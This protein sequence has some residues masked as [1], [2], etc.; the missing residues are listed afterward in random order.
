MQ[1]EDQLPGEQISA[2]KILD[3]VY[4]KRKIVKPSTK[5]DVLDLEELRELQRRKRAEFET[6]LKRNKLDIGQWIR[7]A[8]F[9]VEQRDIRRAR[10][11]FERALLVD[12]SHVPLWIRYIDTEIKLK[13]I[14]HARNLLNRA[15]GVLPRVDKFW[16]KYLII[17]ESLGNLEIVR[18]LFTKWISLEPGPNAWE[19]FVSF[20][21]RQGNWNHVREVFAKYVLVHPK[22]ETWLRWVNFETVHGDTDTVR[23]VYSLALDTTVSMTEK[24]I[25]NDED[26]A[27]LIV[28]FADWEG[29]QQEY[30][31]CRQLYKVSVQRWPHN[32]LLK[33]GLLNFEKRF[34]DT[35][36][37]EQGVLQRRRRRYE[38]SLKETP[39]DYDTCW[40][41]L[42]LI[43]N[44]FATDMLACF[45]SSVAN[46]QPQEVTKTS[47]WK[48]YIYLWIRYLAYVELEVGNIELCRELYERLIHLIP[49][50]KFTFAKVWFMYSQFEVRN[51]ELSSARRIMGKALGM[52]PKPKIFKLYIDMEVKLKEF[53][54]VRKLYEKYIEY[55]PSNMNAWRA[56]AE[57]ESNL[58]DHQRAVGIYEMSLMSDIAPLSNDSRIEQ[59][60]SFID[61]VTDQEE[62]DE[63]R[64]LFERFLEMSNYSVESWVKYALFESDT[65]TMEQAQ[66]LREQAK[67]SKD[68]DDEIEFVVTDVNRKMSRNIFERAL[69]YFKTHNQTENRAIVLEAYKSYENIYGN[70]ES[71]AE[72]NKRLP[73]IS[74]NIEGAGE[75]YI[76]PDDEGENNSP[77]VSKLQALAK[78]WEQSRQN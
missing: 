23:K 3:E 53:D 10:S 50:K 51:G 42:D 66:I 72:V 41:Y 22:A 78:K 39:H 6:Y 15:V 74:E 11:V 61:Y 77:N 63:A 49:H 47:A 57:L 52:C 13:N 46:T 12:N 17:E 21:M 73:R 40:L 34:G 30:E 60:Q 2:E 37:I 1:A 64:E 4:K 43:Q 5:V 54:R 8:R 69:D 67:D 29:T 36:S 31:R 58:G 75:K 14:N 65:P 32:D 55:N 18:S 68:D 27:A 26:I 59:M 45:E 35:E 56:Y 44:N 38:E 19:S 7:Y 9:E 70:L 48:R 76:F 24:I 20:E 71:Q 62:F 16:Y 25:V 33:E 28:S